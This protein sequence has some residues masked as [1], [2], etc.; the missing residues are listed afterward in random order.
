MDKK[1]AASI[2]AFGVAIGAGG[3]QL[4]ITAA[5]GGTLHTQFQNE[6]TWVSRQT[7]E[8]SEYGHRQCVYVLHEDGGHVLEPCNE[9]TLSPE[10][11]KAFEAFVALADAGSK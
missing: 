3:R 7:K 8:G 6:Q 5:D 11:A 9:W 10:E 2:L 4:L 1:L